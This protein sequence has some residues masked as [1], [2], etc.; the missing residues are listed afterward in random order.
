MTG[1]RQRRPSG[2][3]PRGI[4]GTEYSYEVRLW[5]IG[6]TN[7]KTN[8]HHVRW[9]V[10]GKVK[11]A[12][13]STYALADSFRSELLQAMRK[14]EGFELVTGLPE[15]KLRERPTSRSWFDFCRDYVAMRWKGAAAK[16]RDSI[17]DALATASLALVDPG[18]GRPGDTELRT[19]VRW[20][21]LPGNAEA[22]PP[23]SMASALRWLERRSLPLA[24]LK[25]PE[26]AH[27]V[28]LQ[29]T[30]KLDGKPAAGDTARRRRRVLNTA[31]EHA[32]AIGELPENPLKRVKIKRSTAVDRV[33][34]RVVVNRRQARQLLVAVSYVGSWDRGRGR[35]LVA[36][37]ATLYYA[38]M[39]P[40][41]AV[42][43]RIEDCY[44]PSKGWGRLTLATTRPVAGKQFTDSGRRHDERGLKQRDPDEERPVPIPPALVRFLR[45]HIAEFGI[46]EDG[47]I[48]SNER[49]GI[50]GAS[51]YSRAWE[52]ARQLALPPTKVAS[53]LA[54]RPYDLRHAAITLWL[55]EAVPVAEIARRVGN[56][57]EVIH[58]R[59][60]GCV[61]GQEQAINDQIQAAFGDE[62]DDEV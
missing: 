24:L 54:G 60:E 40:A 34:P 13:F 10:A 15:S 29:L 21:L 9:T 38:G 52:D 18:Q 44:L 17:T 42:G 32:V 2:R 5:K 47:R 53:P 51:T 6:K 28:L 7:S 46:A 4:P 11:S 27:R 41:E 33:D 23:K 20:A 62:D 31:V 43:L 39:R 1:S 30:L 61:D 36:F 16:T 50:L 48:F 8:P 59:Y 22:P 35:R 3:H 55:N 12:T 25:E 26:T 37:F 58:K 56:S 49:G 19:A 14:G 45:E 57:T